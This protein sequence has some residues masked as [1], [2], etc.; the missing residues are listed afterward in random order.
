MRN[1]TEI[2]SRGFV[3]PMEEGSFISQAQQIVVRTLDASTSEERAD[4][5]VMQEKVRADL[6]RFNSMSSQR[7]PLFMPVILEV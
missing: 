4:W 6:R 5:G 2:V 7:R 1:R 3:A